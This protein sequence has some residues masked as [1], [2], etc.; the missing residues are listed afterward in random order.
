M[1]KKRI[2]IADDEEQI[3]FCISLAL[4]MIGHDA[5]TVD[6]GYS[7]L[8]EIERSKINNQPFDLLICD[9][10]MPGLTGEDL[11]DALKTRFLELPFLIITGYGEKA[12]VVRMMRKG[13]RDFID[14]PFEPD[15]IEKRVE[16]IFTEDNNC[17]LEQK[18]LETLA[19][20]GLHTRQ[21]VHDMN[22]VLAG[23]QGYADMALEGL[24]QNHPVRTYLTKILRTTN[25]AAELC[26]NALAASKCT[27]PDPF[28]VT[29]MN[30]ITDRTAEILRDVVAENVTIQT[31]TDNVP[32]WSK[33]NAERIQQ[34]LLNLGINAAQAMPSGG[35]LTI[36]CS[37]TEKNN[38]K[39]I[40][41]SVSD[42]GVGID[43]SI[44]SKIFDNGFSTKDGGNGIGLH[45]VK[46]IVREHG[47]T[48][49][50]DSC[51]ELGTTFTIDLIE[52]ETVP[53]SIE[54]TIHE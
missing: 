1:N 33:I 32:V 4:R 29:E 21:L 40:R 25:R 54:R 48:I 38:I 47:G 20:V 16:M 53:V 7:A 24:E 31:K 19:K 2:L 39:V 49:R 12:L 18:R 5:V 45:T 37:R 6:N 46:E 27:E 51:L 41:L 52:Q 11:I 15:E 13:C 9:I 50:V 30:S 14:K 44:I 23:T 17:I 28:K 43:K 8:Q 34:A 42:S 3:R 22:N 10:Q 26:S 35:K 36:A